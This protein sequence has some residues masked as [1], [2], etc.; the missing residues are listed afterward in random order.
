MYIL[1]S[2]PRPRRVPL[3]EGLAGACSMLEGEDNFLT[4]APR[5]LRELAVAAAAAS[6]QAAYTYSVSSNLLMVADLMFSNADMHRCR[7]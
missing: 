3:E 2:H 7:K 1:S 4:G 6:G 5:Q